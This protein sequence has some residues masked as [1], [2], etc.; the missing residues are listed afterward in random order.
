MASR[1]GKK[2]ESKVLGTIKKHRLAGRTDRV[3]VACSGGKDS[4]S[5][6]SIMHKDGYPV[7][8]LHIDLGIGDWSVENRKNIT[9]FC[10]DG[11]IKLHFAS[12]RD[13]FGASVCYIKSSLQAKTSLTSCSICGVM[14]KTILSRKAREL[15]AGRLATGHNLDD[16]AR[17]FTM[18]LLN[19]NPELCLLSGPGRIHGGSGFVPRIKPLYFCPASEIRRYSEEMNFPVLYERCPCSKGSFGRNIYEE[20]E[21]LERTYPGLRK[22]IVETFLEI[23]GKIRTRNEKLL[24]CKLCGEPSRKG[25]CR[26]CEMFSILRAEPN[27]PSQR[28]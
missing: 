26:T 3:L 5:V 4:T 23:Q 8:A 19:G 22:N 7:E 18:N 11:G 12:T 9:S 20:L 15:G 24:P 2:F 17:T 10:K 25:V 27:P 1:F 21:K 13:Y 28:R 16:E 6:L 14:K